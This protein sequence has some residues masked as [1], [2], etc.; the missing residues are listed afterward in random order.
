MSS[1]RFA[2]ISLLA[3]LLASVP[4]AADSSAQCT[5][6]F[7]AVWSAGTHPTD[8]P[9][10]AHF[11][12]LIGATH[13]N[14][15]VFWQSGGLASPGIK[16]MAETGITAQLQSEVQGAITMGTA[17]DIVLGGGIAT[18]PGNVSVSFDID[19]GFPELTLVTMIAPSPDW[20]VGVH[21]LSLFENGLWR[22][23]TV[24]DLPPYDAGTD[25]GISF[26]SG[27]LPTNPPDPISPITGHP[28]VG[29]T[30]LGTFTIDC[31]SALLFADGFEDGTLDV[32]DG[33]VP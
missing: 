12:N 3:A 28:F 19:L 17:A 20:F 13:G 31:T 24:V 5:L 4:A 27:N 30:S 7:S 1:R 33:A 22:E 25:S 11:S 10:G 23:Q 6:E 26:L 18:S 29:G 16:Q 32:W 21:G 2:G 8:F 15:V 14:Q 9:P